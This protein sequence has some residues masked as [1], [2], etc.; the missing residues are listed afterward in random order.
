MAPAPNLIGLV[1]GHCD[2]EH[3]RMMQKVLLVNGDSFLLVQ[4][5][6]TCRPYGNNYRRLKAKGVKPPLGQVLCG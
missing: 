4:D 6:A 3:D 1:L 5:M 2:C